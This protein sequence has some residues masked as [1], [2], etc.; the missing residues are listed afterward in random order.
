MGFKRVHKIHWGKRLVTLEEVSEPN[1]RLRDTGC[2]QGILH[3]TWDTSIHFRVGSDWFLSGCEQSYRINLL[4]GEPLQNS[5]GRFDE[6]LRT[7][8]GRLNKRP[9]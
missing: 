2:F 6:D 8:C 5:L 1:E 3:P 7:G 4:H 9:G